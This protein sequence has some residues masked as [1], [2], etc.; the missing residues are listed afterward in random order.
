MNTAENS[1]KGTHLIFP[2]S[3]FCLALAIAYFA[4]ELYQFRT[5]F[6]K[7]LVKM[8]KTSEVIFPTVNGIAE[9][10]RNISPIAGEIE[11]V[12]KSLPDVLA[13]VKATRESLPDILTQ[14]SVILDKTNATTRNLP[15]V[16]AEA[17]KIRETVPGIVKEIHDINVQIPHMIKTAD[18]IREQIPQMIQTVD[19]ASGAMLSFTAEITEINKSIPAILEETQKTREAMPGILDRAEKIVTQG[20]QFGSEASKGAV[21]GLVMGVVDPFNLSARLKSL[22]LPGKENPALTNAD[23]AY[24]RETTIQAIENATPGEFIPWENPASNNFGETTLLEKKAGSDFKCSEI[25]IEIWIKKSWFRKSK[26]HD[27][28]TVLCRQPDGTYIET[29]DAM[30]NQGER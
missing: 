8:E 5:D 10:S 13:E 27:F 29:G 15:Q 9:I 17:E 19:T 2:L 22:V 3:I 4:F 25:R 14:I 24:I 12:R 1:K 28:N 11:E 30:L 7:I 21:T 18:G 20:Q 26:T 16:L 6:P 23:I